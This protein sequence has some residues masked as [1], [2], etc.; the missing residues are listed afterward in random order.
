MEAGWPIWGCGANPGAS[1]WLGLKA[2]ALG[3]ERHLGP[4]IDSD[5]LEEDRLR[6]L[7][8]S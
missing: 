2:V 8:H 6:D 7:G 1:R 4:E 5:R 3:L